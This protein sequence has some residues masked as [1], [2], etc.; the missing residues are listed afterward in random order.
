MSRTYEI[1]VN[2]DLPS[3]VI[4]WPQC[5]HCGNDVTINDGIA[6]REDCR[7]QFK[8]I[9]DDAGSIPDPN[10]EGTDVPC[11]VVAGKQGNPHENERARFEPH[12]P[13]PCILP[14]G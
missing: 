8:S 4:P 5:G 13:E 10:L 7:V 6:W 2:G 1:V 9:D 12:P 3:L 11:G 14:S